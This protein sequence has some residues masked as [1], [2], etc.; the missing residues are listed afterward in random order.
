MKKILLSLFLCTQLANLF[1]YDFTETTIEGD[2][3][4]YT[5]LSSNTVE[6][7]GYNSIADSCTIPETII[8][9]STYTVTKIGYMAFFECS[10]LASITIPNSVTFIGKN[11]FTSCS[12]LTSLIIPNSVTTLG[13]YCFASCSNL[14][15]IIIPNSVTSIG[16][17]CFFN[18]KW[19]ENKPDG[20]VSINNILLAYNGTC[21]STVI[22]PNSITSISGGAFRICTD[23]TE[24][25]IPN[26]VTSIGNGAF[27]GCFKLK[28]ITIPS[29]VTIIERNAFE[30]TQWLKDKPDGMVIINSVLYSYNGTCPSTITIPNTVATIG[31]WIFY[32]CTNLTSITIPNSVTSIGE[33][34]FMDCSNLASITIPNSVT[35]IGEGTF[36]GCESAGFVSISN[37]LTS[38]ENHTFNGCKSLKT[39]IVP[40]SV[41]SI[42]KSAFYSCESIISITLPSSI[43]IIG[44]Y[45]FF[46][47]DTENATLESKD[48]LYIKATTPPIVTK[49]TFIGVSKLVPIMIP[50]GTLEA[51]STAPYWSDFVNLIEI[52]EFP[53]YTPPV[54]PIENATA[55]SSIQPEENPISIIH[56]TLTI[57]NSK[58]KTV[59]IYKLTGT[60][61]YKSSE[62]L[63]Q[64]QL[65]KGVYIICID[66]KSYKVIL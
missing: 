56:N 66:K 15:S 8:K 26:S 44:S 24:I 55:I 3:L 17:K 43:T 54:Q 52:D 20:M 13:N 11:A 29:S 62:E 48:T 46:Y 35:T 34:A 42:D 37:S 45:T 27:Y 49:N 58:H 7:S 41:T 61:V 5:I 14:T 19:L 40:E 39:I 33:R 51:Y 16:A 18:T 10:S 12:N 23:L 64:K 38:I 59:A 60:A 21:P 4:Q 6:L 1:A 65:P 36:S 57:E 53:T 50:S 28:S 9:N 22:I 47:C 32:N 2:T 25:T 31:E 63:I 30:T